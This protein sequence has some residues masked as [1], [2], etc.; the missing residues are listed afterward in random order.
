MDIGSELHELAGI[1]PTD[2]RPIVSV[3]LNTRW[4]DE[5]QRRRVRLFVRERSRSA[6]ALFDRAE[7]TGR[8]L[9]R[10]LDRL[11]QRVDALIEAPTDAAGAAFFLSEGH[12]LDKQLLFHVPL[13]P[14]FAVGAAPRVL[15][16]A[17]LS[18]VYRPLLLA[19]IDGRGA[20]VYETVVGEL[21][22]GF[23]MDDGVPV[24]PLRSGW[25]QRRYQRRVPERVREHHAE[26]ATVLTQLFDR[27]PR[28][29]L[30]V[31]GPEDQAQ[32]VVSIL[33]RRLQ[34]ALLETLH[35]KRR[36]GHLDA[37][38]ETTNALLEIS[39]SGEAREA[40]RLVGEALA[41]GL[42]VVGP[43][44]V[45]RATAEGRVQTLVIDRNA[46]LPGWRCIGCDALGLEAHAGCPYCGGET[47]TAELGEELARR[48]LEAGGEVS[49]LDDG[50]RLRPFD[51]VGA[52]LRHRG[53]RSSVDQVFHGAF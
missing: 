10:D 24:R 51:G 43:E 42:A 20:E 49:V 6:R 21:A 29:A 46:S 14:L 5:Q 7:P 53:N 37:L 8:A 25:Y 13:E 32:Q 35:Q 38:D 19:V 9:G 4:A 44:D 30:I 33:P 50:A 22:L 1:V 27:D 12:D 31:A 23:S 3:M 18:S 45:A 48:V 41:G 36:M 17:R 39:R 11:E 40:D 26:V 47:S 15:P 28:T 16:L 52:L 34:E 2:E